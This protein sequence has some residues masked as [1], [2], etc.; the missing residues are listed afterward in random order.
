[1]ADRRPSEDGR[2]QR[3]PLESHLFVSGKLL[4]LAEL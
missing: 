3:T 1:M 2:Y 4:A